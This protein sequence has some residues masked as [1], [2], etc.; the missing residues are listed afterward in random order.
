MVFQ[1][2]R[3][4]DEELEKFY[5]A[6]YRLLVQDDEGPS[7]KDLR[8]QSGRA[9]NLLAFAQP[10]LHKVQAHL[11]IGSS[12]GALLLEFRRAYGCESFG[13]EP[14]EA[15]RSFSKKLG[16]QVVADLA[17]LDRNQRKSFD[18]IT[19]AHVLEHVPDPVGYLDELRELWLAPNGHLLIEVPNLFGHPAF[20]LA[21][22]TAFSKSTLSQILH[23][24]GYQVVA[25]KVHGAPRSH[26]IPLYVTVLAGGSAHPVESSPLRSRDRWIYFRRRLGKVWNRWASRIA[27]HWAWLPLPEVLESLSRSVD[28]QER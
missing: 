11:D 15:Y 14:G 23:E 28:A 19:M 16:L 2:P 3:M 8:I 4:A 9:R 12:A 7:D 21:H 20:E 18:L 6:D 10:Y 5:L 22:L 26:I 24:A 13:V 25:Q 1:S 17:D 27:P